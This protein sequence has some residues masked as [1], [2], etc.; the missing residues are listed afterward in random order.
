M[1]TYHKSYGVS[2]TITDKRDGTAQLVARDST[3]K[4]IREKVYSSRKAAEAAWRRFC[5]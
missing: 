2:A 5:N 1:K 4:K 3:G